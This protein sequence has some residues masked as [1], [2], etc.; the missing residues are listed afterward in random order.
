MSTSDDS[1]QPVVGAGCLALAD[2]LAEL[3]PSE[4]DTPSLCE[5]WR[6]REVVA[7]LTMPARYSEEAFMAELRQCGFD[8]TVLSNRVA[9]RDSELP[10][11]DLVGQLR[12]DVMQHWTPPGGGYA[13]ALNHVVVHGL[14]VT[15]PL[16]RPR[17][18]PDATVRQVLEDLTSGGVH[19]HFGTEI[20]GRLVATDIDWS[21]GDGREVTGSAQD[22]ILHLTARRNPVESQTPV[23]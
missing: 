4:W 19:A 10:S 22:L 13:G 18:F 11:A 8:F 14:D 7:H 15:V 2:F 5:G 3:S 1:L 23:R 17:V 12:S 20:T 6:L 16:G 9:S 21:H